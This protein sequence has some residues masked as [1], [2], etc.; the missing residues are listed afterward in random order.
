MPEVGKP[1]SGRRPVAPALPR[2]Q[3]PPE[4]LRVRGLIMCDVGGEVQVIAPEAAL[5]EHGRINQTLD[6]K[7]R[8]RMYDLTECTSAIPGDYGLPVV[9]EKSLTTVPELALV[10]A[11]S[12]E[13]FRIRGAALTKQAFDV[14]AFPFTVP[15]KGSEPA[16][17]RDADRM[18]IDSAVSRFTERRIQQRLDQTLHIPPLPEA[19]RR[20]VA[21]QA[22]DDY[23]L[24]DLVAI[25][26]TDPSIAARIMG[27]ANSAFYHVNPPARSIEDA[28]M[29]VLGFD[30]VLSMALGMSLGTTLRLP[31]AHVSGLPPYWLDAVYTAATMEALARQIP[32]ARRPERGL[33]YLAGLLANFGTLVVGHVFPPQYREICLLQEVNRHLPHLHADRHVLGVGREVL[34]SALLEQWELPEEICDSIR[35]QHAADYRGSNSTYVSLLRIARQALGNQGITDLPPGDLELGPVDSA[36]G[37]T[38]VQLDNVLSLI[39]DSREQLDGLA[40][41]M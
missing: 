37:L 18:R 24:K 15:V 13:Y 7:L 33:C 11:S 20:I 1:D 36:L 30:T 5:I 10:G 2:W 27:W 17:S 16:G 9:L 32:A 25:I 14:R 29:R 26:E 22:S 21:L 4:N 6:R 19:A 12:G 28:V 8:A 39:S 41:V 23:D 40:A 3:N 35:F 34:A 38:D 31:E